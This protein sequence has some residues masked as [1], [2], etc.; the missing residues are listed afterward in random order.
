[1]SVYRGKEILFPFVTTMNEL[2]FFVKSTDGAEI[3]LSKE[4]NRYTFYINEPF[5][6]YNE[7][8]IRFTGPTIC[9]RK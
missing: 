3:E 6:H 9:S 4:E 7:E 8:K 1:M 5:F 2:G